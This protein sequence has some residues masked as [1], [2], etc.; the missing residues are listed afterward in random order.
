MY[1]YPVQVYINLLQDFLTLSLLQLLYGLPS[2]SIDQELDT[3]CFSEFFY[4][5]L[6]LLVLC[7]FL[8]NEFLWVKF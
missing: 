6:L 3:E 4:R 1:P 5:D 8:L 7:R 2:L